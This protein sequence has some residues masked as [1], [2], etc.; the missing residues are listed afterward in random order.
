MSRR[1][2]AAA[3]Q[4]LDYFDVARLT[5]PH[6]VQGALRAVALTE[7]VARFEALT[8]SRLRRADGALEDAPRELS[9]K[10]ANRHYLVHIDGVD[11]REAAEALRGAYVTVA[12]DA[13]EPLPEGRWYVADLLG[14]RVRDAEHGDCG[15]LRDIQA[16][17]SND[18]WF[19]S[20]PGKREL[21][22]PI[23]DDSIV[24]V[25]LEARE[26]ELRLPPGLWDVYED[27]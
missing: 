8:S 19:L 22:V 9:V 13:L 2:R 27:G 14:C 4:P 20:R 6:G 3:W 26:I 10:R 5:A 21:L 12:R 15:T 7:D 17:N 18:V 11:S 1:Q 25:D 16:L 24:S 23:L